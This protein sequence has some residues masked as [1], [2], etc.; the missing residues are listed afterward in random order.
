[1]VHG[2]SPVSDSTL[3]L[4]QDS[5]VQSVNIR[6]LVENLSKPVLVQHRFPFVPDR[7]P[8]CFSKVLQHVQVRRVEML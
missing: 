3:Q 2:G 6:Q 4:I 8:H 5:A 1:M 7:C